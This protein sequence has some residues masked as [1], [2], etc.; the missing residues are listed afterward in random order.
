VRNRPV[1]PT[2]SSEFGMYGMQIRVAPHQYKCNRSLTSS[3]D[4]AGIMEHC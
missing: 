2:T 4:V 3:T 1:S